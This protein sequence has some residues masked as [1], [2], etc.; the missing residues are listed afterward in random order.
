LRLA[1]RGAVAWPGR[2]GVTPAP[3]AR[4]S[5][6][7]SFQPWRANLSRTLLESKAQLHIQ[8]AQSTTWADMVQLRRPQRIRLRKDVVSALEGYDYVDIDMILAEFG[9]PISNEWSGTK[10]SYIANG[11]LEADDECLFELAET[12]EVAPEELTTSAT[13]EQ[14]LSDWPETGE[15]GTW[16]N[17]YFRLFLSHVTANKRF[18]GEI[19]TR[20]ATRGVDLFVAHEDIQPSRKWLDQI[21]R[22]LSTADAL[23]ALLTDSFCES[24]WTDQE[25]GFALCKQIP[26]WPL[27]TNQDPHG[28]LGQHQALLC[29]L[30]DAESTAD[31]LYDALLADPKTAPQLR[32]GLVARLRWST[33]YSTSINVSKQLTNVDGL[34]HD[35][36]RLLSDAVKAN[37]QVGGAYGV[38]SRI[39]KILLRNGY[40]DNPN[41]ADPLEF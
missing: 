32:R 23:A 8:K 9:L 3:I 34:T 22:A 39:E 28:F 21:I 17:G 41:S 14:V 6:G 36:L 11:V 20:L 24:Q 7:P 1:E 37:G 30:D 15:E 27:K 10:R 19:K 40:S 4:A 13:S 16:Q 35:E 18:A 2:P 26:I 25:V 12:L 29:D 31:R 38:A 5:A 33:D